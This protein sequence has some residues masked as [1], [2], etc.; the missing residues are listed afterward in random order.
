M[1]PECYLGLGLMLGALIV[2]LFMEGNAR[3]KA[4]MTKIRALATEQQKAGEMV[5]KAREKRR[6]GLGELPVAYVLI[7]AGILLLILAAYLLS[8]GQVF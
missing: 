8:G 2:G 6:E 7:A 4:A 5:Q 1:Q 3:H